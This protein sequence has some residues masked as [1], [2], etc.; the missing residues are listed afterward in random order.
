VLE[1]VLCE[2][3]HVTLNA[4]T[5]WP[6]IDWTSLKGPVILF[7]GTFDPPQAAH[8]EIA[9]RAASCL[10][11][12]AVSVVFIP[13]RLNPHKSN[14]PHASDADRLEMLARALKGRPGWG[15]SPIELTRSSPGPSFTI[16]TVRE[17]RSRLGI[18]ALLYLLMGGDSLLSFP[19][20][21]MPGEILELV[22]GVFVAPRTAEDREKIREV[23][24]GFAPELATKLKSHVLAGTPID[25]SATTVRERLANG[26]SVTGLVPPEVE[27]YI[28]EH[29]LYSPPQ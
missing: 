13:A 22:E 2:E 29:R 25:I 21:R 9:R 6:E 12:E 11:S 10:A 15:I 16:D 26:E 1:L 27:S 14:L 20:W 18:G 4:S 19:R 28:Q 23:A 8:L 17:V 3:V 5:R 24:E 7:G